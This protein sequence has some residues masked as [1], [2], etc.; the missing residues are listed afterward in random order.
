MSEVWEVEM[1]GEERRDLRRDEPV[2]PA[3]VDLN[4]KRRERDVCQER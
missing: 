4:L 2:D 3:S 1:G